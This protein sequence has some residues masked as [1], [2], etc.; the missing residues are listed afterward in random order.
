MASHL[1]LDLSEQLNNVAINLRVT[2]TQI[3]GYNT[4]PSE[5]YGVKNLFE[6]LWRRLT[7]TGFMY[8]DSG[9]ADKYGKEHM[10][11]V[12]QWIAEGSYKPLMHLTEGIDKPAEG[13][14]D[15]L[16]GRCAGKAVLKIR[17]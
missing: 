12:S 10:K 16:E 5:R 14:V 3:A 8:F 7:V 13:L 17:A 1:S 15:M 4:P 6:M 11:N 2:L 9:Y